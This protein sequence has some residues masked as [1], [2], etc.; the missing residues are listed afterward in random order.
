MTVTRATP[1]TPTSP[2]RFGLTVDQL[3]LLQT[4][5]PGLTIPP[6]FHSEWNADVPAD[7]QAERMHAAELGLIDQGL[8]RPA[9]AGADFAA[10]V[11]PAVLGFLGLFTEPALLLAVHSW[12]GRRTIV[13]TIAV[14]AGFAA[15]LVRG[16]RLDEHGT[17]PVNEDAV[18]LS[19]FPVTALIREAL[20]SLVRLEPRG[21][22]PRAAAPAAAVVLPLVLAQGLIGALRTGNSEIIHA[23]AVEVGLPNAGQVV[24]RAAFGIDA[25]YSVV[26]RSLTGD[27]LAVHWFRSADGWFQLSADTP[28][29]STPN[30]TGTP[31]TRDVVDSSRVRL[32]TTTPAA[33]TAQVTTAV[34]TLLGVLRG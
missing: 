7:E 24:G 12:G 6:E 25:G 14:R 26:A 3:Q 8:L 10:R 23:A 30:Q 15:S 22:A 27:T 21:S 19:A 18:E 29:L 20:R 13:Q 32:Q 2:A 17:H 16:Q 33:I 31:S 28:L 34:G 9:P 1:R 4:R 5:C 11:H